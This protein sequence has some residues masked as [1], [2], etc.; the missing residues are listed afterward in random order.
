MFYAA[1]TRG[2]TY[3]AQ[4]DP[5]VHYEE[6]AL[7]YVECYWMMLH[8]RRVYHQ[9]KQRLGFQPYSGGRMQDDRKSLT[10]SPAAAAFI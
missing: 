4:T 6:M 3:S 1:L 9:R 2:K 7:R 8:I 5:C 10:V